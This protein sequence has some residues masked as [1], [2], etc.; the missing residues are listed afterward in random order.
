MTVPEPTGA[1]YAF[2]RLQGLADSFDFCDWLVRYKGVGLAPG[3]AFGLG[4]EGH[5]RLCFAVEEP[6]L[7]EALERLEAGWLAYRSDYRI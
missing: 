6:I 4:G 7:V 5:I 1:F 2:P 3:N